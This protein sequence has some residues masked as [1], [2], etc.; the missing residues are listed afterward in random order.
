M[1]FVFNIRTIRRTYVI[2]TQSLLLR[3][4]SES[5]TIGAIKPTGVV[6]TP[7]QRGLAL[8]R[9]GLTMPL[10][11]LASVV[12]THHIVGVATGETGAGLQERVYTGQVGWLALLVDTHL[13]AGGT[14]TF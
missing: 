12:R 6:S 10:G 5:G 1:S 11:R 3:T 8:K 13:V 4:H 7:K 14:H 2:L 9:G